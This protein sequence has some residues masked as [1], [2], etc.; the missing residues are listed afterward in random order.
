LKINR[1]RTSRCYN[2]IVWF[3][4]P[5]NL[6]TEKNHPNVIWLNA[7]WPNTIWPKGYLTESLLDRTPFD[8]K[9]VLPKRVNCPEVLF[10]ESLSMTI[11]FF[12]FKKSNSQSFFFHLQCP[13]KHNF[14]EWPCYTTFYVDCIVKI[15]K[16]IKEN[17]VGLPLKA[18]LF[19]W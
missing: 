14:C 16:K 19:Y 12:F 9:I 7:T 10:T 18:I 17:M 4:L 2:S 6:F 5:K 13:I 3:I 15:V 1:S 11:L 8:R